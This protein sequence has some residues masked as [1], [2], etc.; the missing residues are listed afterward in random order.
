MTQQQPL[1]KKSSQIR[2]LLEGDEFLHKLATLLPYGMSPKRFVQIVWMQCSKNPRLQQCTPQSFLRCVGELAALG[3]EPDGRRAH[4]IPRKDQCTYIVDYKGIKEQLYRQKDVASEHSDVVREGDIFEYQFGSD[5]FLRHV[6]NLRDR[7]APIIAAYSFVKLP[8]KSEIFEVMSRD[9]I[10]AIQKR[11][12]AGDDGPWITDWAEMAKKTVFRRLAKGLP[13]SDRTRQTV[14]ADDDTLGDVAGP[15]RAAVTPESS[16]ETVDQSSAPE[17]RDPSS[18]EVA[19]EQLPFV[20]EP[21]ARSA[22]QVVFERVTAAGYNEAQLLS[23]LRRLQ[24]IGKGVKSIGD[25]APRKAEEILDDFENLIAQLKE[26][27]PDVG[28]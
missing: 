10:V 11:S 25:I 4:L 13:L 8:D 14:D 15:R 20:N 19:S 12:S 26:D 6:P 24:F 5:S 27:H 7:G 28:S 1:A 3:L 17:P 18:I 21:P 23:T 22:N 2:A 16:Y 9:E